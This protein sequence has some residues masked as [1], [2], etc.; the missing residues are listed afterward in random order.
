MRYYETAFLIAPD[1]SEE[2]TEQLISQMGDIVKKNKGRMMGIDKWGKRKLAYPINKHDSAFYVFFYYE[3]IP[4]TYSELERQFKQKE[5]IIRYLTL[6]K[7]E[8]PSLEEETKEKAKKERPK[9]EEKKE[10]KKTPE[11]KKSKSDSK[12]KTEKEEE[13]QKA[14]KGEK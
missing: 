3:G 8:E 7:E 2:E 11:K 14:K 10:E 6:R 5:T 13:A 12:E 4:E 9:K 1:L